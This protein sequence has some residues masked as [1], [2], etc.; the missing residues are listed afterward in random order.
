MATYTVDNTFTADTTAIASEVNQNFTNVLDALNSFDAANLTGTIS[1]ARISDL[2]ATQ[3]AS[4]FFLDEDNMASNSATAVSSQQAIKAYADTKEATIVTQ[5][6][7][8]VWGARVTTDSL[9][10]TLIKDTVYRAQCDGIVTVYRGQSGGTDSVSAG[11]SNSSNPPT[12]TTLA[13]RGTTGLSNKQ[14]G[15][16]MHV[17]KNDYWTV[18]MTNV[19]PAIYWLPFGTGDSVAQ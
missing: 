19:T 10:A 1:L 15:F 9:S 3:M 14:G 5:T 17:R 13:A 11:Y 2:T 16:S 12:G 8:N 18:T 4:T 6:T 7:A